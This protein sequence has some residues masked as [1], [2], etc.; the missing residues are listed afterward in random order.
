MVFDTAQSMQFQS[1]MEV[2]ARG[3]FAVDRIKYMSCKMTNK[4]D[5]IS[6]SVTK[7]GNR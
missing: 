5:C 1:V 2:K 6:S 7:S 4:H 3:G